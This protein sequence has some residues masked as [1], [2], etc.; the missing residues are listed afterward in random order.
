MAELGGADE[1]Y[2]R[3]RA[4]HRTL[5]EMLSGAEQAFGQ[6]ASALVVVVE[7]LEALSGQLHQHFSL[8]EASECFAEMVAHAPRVADRAAT[9]LGE[10]RQLRE[11]LDDLIAR[12][13]QGGGSPTQ[14]DEV[15]A[16][17]SDFRARLNDHEQRENELMQEVF[18]EDIGSK[19]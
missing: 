13:R 1:L 9:L 12:T 11:L 5:R 4:E 15:S 7:R 2:A 3:V 19:D 14:W 6:G 18:T 16:G 8:E 10:H 17:F